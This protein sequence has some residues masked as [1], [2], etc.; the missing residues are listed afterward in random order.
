MKNNI[1]KIIFVTLSI[2]FLFSCNNEHVHE[3]QNHFCECGEYDEV[4][5]RVIVNCYNEDIIIETVKDEVINI[6]YNSSL[7][8]LE[9]SL[10]EGYVFTG[11]YKDDVLYNFNEIITEEFVLIGKLEKI[12]EITKTYEIKFID[13]NEKIILTKQVSDGNQINLN[14]IKI[15]NLDIEGYEFIGWYLGKELFDFNTIIKS[16]IVLKATYKKINYYSVIF[17]DYNEEI[18]SSE[19]V[20]ENTVI[21][22]PEI[23]L[24]EYFTFKEWI[25]DKHLEDDKVHTDLV[26]KAEYEPIIQDY[27]IEYVIDDNMWYYNSKEE[28]LLD[29]LND[30]YEFINP[31]ESRNVFINAENGF[32]GYWVHYLGGSESNNNKLIYQNNIDL[33]NDEYFLNSTEYKAK[34]YNL[35]LYVRDYICKSNKRFGYPEVEYLHGAL[36]FKR[37]ITNDPATYIQT[38][39]GEDVFYSLP[40]NLEILNSI[41]TYNDEVKLNIPRSELFKGWYLDDHYTDGP[42]LVIPKSSYGNKKYFA[43]ISEEPEYIISFDSNGGTTCESIEINYGDEII[44]PIPNKE[45]YEF[46]GWYLDNE[47]F[48]G[49]ITYK[50]NYSN[51]LKAKWYNPNGINY[52]KLVYDGKVITYRNSVKSVDIPD[53]YE[54]RDE[55]L[56]AIW[57]SS[58]ISSYKPSPIESV[59]K[60]ELTKLLD[61]MEYYN[62]NCVFF[63]LRTHNN[64]FY[65]TDLAPIKEEYGNFENWD[66]LPWLIE[67]CHKRGIEFHAWLNP[68]RIYLSGLSL[69]TT[70][71]DIAKEY[72]NYPKNPASDKDNIL[73]TYATGNKSR[74]AILNPAKEIVQE[75]IKDVC[76]EIIENYDID[77][78]HFDDYFYAKQGLT[79]DI[80][81]DPDQDDYLNYINYNDTTFKAD[82]K[83]DKKDWRRLNVDNLIYKLNETFDSY[84]NKTKRKIT[85]GI[86]P[87][88]VYKSG[89]GSIEGGS[90]TTGGGHYGDYLYSDTYKWAKNGWI[91]YIMPHLYESFTHPNSSFVEKA[92][93]WNKAMEGVDCKLYIGIGISKIIASDYEYAWQTEENELI[94]QLLYLSTLNNVKGISLY[95]INSLKV[96]HSNEDNIAHKAFNKLKQEYWTKKVKIPD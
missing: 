26:F 41:Y 22:Y 45:G 80:L 39:G 15:D 61:L 27:K 19:I 12:K 71:E 54:E 58:F 64:A 7:S 66:Y 53:K 83:D 62:L 89:D 21:N 95:S 3:F 91:D 33:D 57:V 11:W 52:N 28:M 49:T 36:D 81:L 32:D 84:Y 82:S 24:R 50:Y 86:S 74:G 70:C 94:N 73:M 42:Y 2:I 85:F 60:N 34:W 48:T 16:N 93:W 59:M 75:Y 68:Y 44:L 69:D 96:V 35:S 8:I 17:L 77:G 72:E 63:H 87:T 78:I 88:G 79:P 10:K 51:I 37:Y 1:I 90:Y 56:R 25:C 65:K 6:K 55:E 38:Y 30:F 29:F 46:V 18:I 9:E 13:F 67:E 5:V 92:I 20:L 31:L 40:N 4:Q 43:K 23:P 14:E 76:M 47:L